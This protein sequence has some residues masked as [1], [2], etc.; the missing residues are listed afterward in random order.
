MRV[1]KCGVYQIQCGANSSIYIGSSKQI[2]TRWVQHR[3]H[4]RSG[5]HTGRYL[6]HAWSKHGEKS[7]HFSIL[8]E[9]HIAELEQREQFYIDK[10]AP[11][12]NAIT[13]IERR[14]GKEYR[15]RQISATKAH[16]AAQTHCKNGHEYVEENT[17]LDKKGYR[18]CRACA[19]ERN[20]RVFS[21]LTLRQKEKRLVSVKKYL[22]RTREDRIEKMREYTTRTKERKHAYDIIYRQIK[23]ARRQYVR[24][25]EINP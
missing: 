10:L 21:A 14:Y 17:Y 16:F 15:V 23:N 1:E 3:Y 12:L 4:L 13:S 8:E 11:K 22:Q 25:Q 2:Y 20:K 5:K 18:R 9:C 7:F 24:D 6:Q 19:R